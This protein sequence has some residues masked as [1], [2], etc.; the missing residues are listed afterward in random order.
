[1]PTTSFTE[2]LDATDLNAVGALPGSVGSV[3]DHR[4]APSSLAV[5]VR[6]WHLEEMVTRLVDVCFRGGSGC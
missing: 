4:L 2:G 6:L 1:M 3:V 5:E